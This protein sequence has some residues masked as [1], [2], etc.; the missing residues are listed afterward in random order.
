MKKIISL[1]IISIHN[2]NSVYKKYRELPQLDKE[3]VHGWHDCPRRI[4]EWTNQ[5]TT[6]ISNYSKDDRL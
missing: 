2:K 1:Y 4:S 6:G 3:Y 5:E